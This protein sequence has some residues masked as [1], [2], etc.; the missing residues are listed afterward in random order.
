MDSLSDPGRFF[1]D[2]SVDWRDMS[3]AVD[4]ERFD[5]LRDQVDSHAVVGIT[6]GDGRVCCYDDGSHGWTLPAATVPAGGD[7]AATARSDLGD[8]LGVSLALDAP[9]RI[10]HVGFTVDDDEDARRVDTY[11]VVFPARVDGETGDAA[12]AIETDGDAALAWFDAVPAGQD[13]ELADDVRLFL[14]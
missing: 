10:R 3:H 7:W 4:A 11:D 8:L 14:D 5:G 13:G 2:D 12:G 6:D 9:R 1:D